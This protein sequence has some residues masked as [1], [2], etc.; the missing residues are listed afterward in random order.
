MSAYQKTGVLFVTMLLVAALILF[1]NSKTSVTTENVVQ[2]LKTSVEPEREACGMTFGQAHFDGY[3][4]K[5][6]DRN[7]NLYVGLYGEDGELDV[8]MRARPDRSGTA[9]YFSSR[10]LKV[11]RSVSL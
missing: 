7:G 5:R 4:E 9:I 10:A 8:I 1:H 3:C 11:M 2:T 6:Y